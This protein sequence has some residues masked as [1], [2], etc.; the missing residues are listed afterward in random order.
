M[1]R[2]APELQYRATNGA[3]ALEAGCLVRR[4]RLFNR[5]LPSPP[6]PC[7]RLVSPRSSAQ[8]ATDGGTAHTTE[9]APRVCPLIWPPRSPA[10]PERSP[11]SRRWTARTATRSSTVYRRRRSRRRES[12]AVSWLRSTGRARPRTEPSVTRM[13]P[14]TG[15]QAAGMP[16]RGAAVGMPRMLERHVPPFLERPGHV[17]VEQLGGNQPEPP[18]ITTAAIASSSSPSESVGSPTVSVEYSSTPATPVSAPA[19]A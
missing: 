10:T 6:A 7:S 3:E 2:C 12:S 11:S 18:P 15:A 14:L 8:S 16:H 9:R 4:T 17:G 1:A 13:S 5:S 19:S